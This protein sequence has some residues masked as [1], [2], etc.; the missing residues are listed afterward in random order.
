MSDTSDFGLGD[1]ASDLLSHWQPL[2]DL[3]AIV[4][5]LSLRRAMRKW[6]NNN[7]NCAYSIKVGHCDLDC[8]Q[9]LNDVTMSIL[10]K[11][12][13]NESNMPRMQKPQ[14]KHN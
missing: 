3:I 6:V 12:D 9:C 1:N 4:E 8:S 14:R 11:G 10:I 7:M 13:Q 2:L 5:P